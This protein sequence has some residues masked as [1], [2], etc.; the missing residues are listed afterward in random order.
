MRAP[1][2]FW[3]R[4]EEG[5][6]E[7][8]REGGRGKE[9]ER[10]KKRKEWESSYLER[11]L[12]VSGLCQLDGNVSLG[13]SEDDIM[14]SDSREDDNRKADS[15][16]DDNMKADSSE[17]DN[18]KAD[19]SEDDI[20]K[21]D[22]SE[23]DYMNS[24]K[25]D[26]RGDFS[27]MADSSEQ[28]SGLLGRP[29]SIP[30]HWGFRPPR[31]P[32]VQRP[33]PVRSTIRRDNRLVEA[34]SAP[35][36]TLYNARSVWSKWSNLAD[37]ILMRQTDLCI[38]TEVWE[39]LENKKH[40]KAIESMFETSGIKYVSTPRPGAR[41]GGGT[42]L[43]CSSERF[44]LTK[45]NVPIPS[46]LEACFAL[47]KPKKPTGKVNTFI[48]GS[49]YSP[50]RSRCK[51]K[52]AEFLAVTLCQLRAEH[53]DSA[54]I[55]GADINDMTLDLLFSLDPTLRQIVNFN[56]NKNDDK[57]LDVIITDCQRLMQEP[58]RLAPL[59]VDEGKR[60]VDSD[61]KGVEVLPRAVSASQG[62]TLRQ[63][64][65]VQPFPESGLARFGVILQKKDWGELE[66]TLSST[67]MV[68]RFQAMSE[69]LVD[70]SFAKK[71]VLVGD[72][73]QPYFTEELRRIK[74][75]RQRAYVTHG[76][77][78]DRYIALRRHFEDKLRQEAKKYI[79]KIET[80]VTEGKRGSAYSAIR[81]LGNRP[82]ESRNR[83]FTLPSFVSEQMT[84]QQEAD[85]LADYFSSISQ[86]VVPMVEDQF[87]PSLRQAVQEGRSSPLRPLLTEHQ[88]YTKMLRIKKPNSSVPG[89]V[90]RTLIK[91]F[92]F[93]YSVPATKI[94][95]QIIKTS[96][97]PRQW[98]QEHV[99]VLTKSKTEAPKS[100]NDLRNISKTAFFSKL[101]EALIGDYLMP[102]I[103]KYIDPGQCG[104]LKGTSITHYLVKLIDFVHKTLDKNTPHAAILCTEDYSKAYNRGSFPLVM[105]DL[106]AMHTPPW[107]L[108]I[109][110][111]YLSGRSM[112]LSF[113][114]A[115]AAPRDL[116][117]GFGQG[118][119]LGGIL[120]I[121]KFNGACLRPAI[122]R[123]RT[124]NTAV[125]VKYIDD[126]TQ[127][128]SVNLKKSLIPDP[129]ERPRPL[130]YS[131]R[132]RMILNPQENVLQ[133]EV[134]SFCRFTT[135]N[136]FV[137]NQSKCY[138]MKFNRSRKFDFPAEIDIGGGRNVEVVPTLK[139]LGIQV[140]NTLKWN[141]QIRQMTERAT[142]TIWVIRR[143]KSVGV[144]QATL[145][146]YWVAEG[147]S[148]LEMCAPVWHSGLT[149][150]QSRA[151]ARVQRVAMAAITSVWGASHT[152]QLRSLA[153][154]PLADRRVELCRRF[155]KRTAEKSRHSDMFQRVEN[156]RP[157]RQAAKKPAYIEKRARTAA[158]RRSPLPYLTRLL[159]TT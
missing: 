116:P 139:I 136:R 62:P 97:W 106:H 156:P 121:V 148:A 105:E 17:E 135:E 7:D 27:M 59:Q 48:C 126:A 30:S 89:D 100:E 128:A 95:N 52:M 125:K 127:A 91:E 143:M 102:I 20:M 39:K 92:P 40:Q 63:R 42:A 155:A 119:W 146:K 120:F 45:I 21:A 77:R 28:L 61:H 109:I 113:H 10:E 73:D 43:A 38:L 80:E 153:L 145:V 114:G 87:P 32:V 25:A 78:S 69:D 53:P 101:F 85:K 157:A 123:P 33:R 79:N 9:E 118:V 12:D 134:D 115:T 29:Q 83:N 138:V 31:T 82:G 130:N 19:S 90:P 36:V 158:Y 18:M 150:A 6:E 47:L 133:M 140:E 58:T 55:L 81:K 71:S 129:R 86:Q 50:P 96:V 110:F 88:V 111:S 34:L 24:V 141:A 67:Q 57:T 15:S 5:R 147:R 65:V 8:G 1:S 107:L 2:S 104:G 64:I 22:C 16:E 144:S 49:F 94:F 66:D 26:I 154:Q 74:R 159:N 11:K 98:V 137:I 103:T 68:D 76:K 23:E 37:D 152:E 44:S 131:E 99:I 142:K 56:T 14:I 108:S 51:T 122:P 35:R 75:R 54:V 117:G 93:E 60:G 151:L 124:G 41:R 3:G 46:P 84:P 70:M 149:A 4:E 72:Q 112:I 13:G 132:T